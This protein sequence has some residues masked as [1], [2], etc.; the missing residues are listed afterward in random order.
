MWLVNGRLQHVVNGQLSELWANQIVFV[1]DRDIHLIRRVPG[2]DLCLYNVAVPTTLLS[3]IL[4]VSGPEIPAQHWFDWP[5]PPKIQIHGEE[6][7]DVQVAFHRAMDAFLGSPRE[8]DLLQFLSIVLSAMAGPPNRGRMHPVAPIWLHDALEAMDEPENLAMGLPRLQEL[9]SV[10]PEH[11]CRTMHAQLGSTPTEYINNLRLRRAT[12]LL[13]SSELS[14][15]RIAD[16]C[17]FQSLSYLHRLFRAKYGCSPI[18]FRRER[19]ALS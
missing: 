5:S 9:A 12:V 18:A 2:H 13:A 11:L 16:G 1:R 17:G 10:S 15:A 3:G 7:Q 14:L 6:I 8:I 4:S 19:S